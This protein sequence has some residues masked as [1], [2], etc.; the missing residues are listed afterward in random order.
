LIDRLQETRP[1]CGVDLHRATNDLFGQFF[2]FN[3]KI[4]S[5][6]FILSF[7]IP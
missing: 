3:F 6:L 1:D 7:F 5:I 2:L 4:L